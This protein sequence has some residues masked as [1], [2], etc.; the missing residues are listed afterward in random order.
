MRELMIIEQVNPVIDVNFEEVK[1]D[2]ESRL[3]EYTKL[4]VTE[5]SLTFCKNEQKHLAG[6]RKKIDTYRKDIKKQMNE[7]IK[8]FE[9]KCKELIALVEETETPIKQGINVFDDKR[10]ELKKLYA[11]G[12]ISRLAN[13]LQL[14]QKYLEQLQVIDKYM[15]L[16]AKEKDVTAD[17]ESRAKILKMEQDREEQVLETISKTIER[18]N[19]TIT[20]DLSM[21]DFLFF[22]KSDKSLIEI[23][24]E[25]EKK[26]AQIKESEERVKKEAEIKAQEEAQKKLQVDREK[27]IL[28]TKEEVKKEIMKPTDVKENELTYVLRLTGSKEK[29]QDLKNFLLDNDIKFDKLN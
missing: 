1:L 13:E 25:I 27:L 24:D 28:E 14:S 5:E 18:V 23:I 21:R 29:L 22:I 16:T 6:L 26:A 4:V 10:R 19:K 20:Q 2:L 8:E 11:I 12:E 15:N 3:N 7:P 9:N 17:I